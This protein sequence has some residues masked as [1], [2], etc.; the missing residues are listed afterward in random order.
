MSSKPKSADVSER[1]SMMTIDRASGKR[2]RM[3]TASGQ[4]IWVRV[5]IIEKKRGGLSRQEVKLHIE[6][7]RSVKI[8]REEKYLADQETAVAKGL[9]AAIEKHSDKVWDVEYDA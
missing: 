4:V 8:D 3:E 2:V 6:A 5:T 1:P 9:N 7:P